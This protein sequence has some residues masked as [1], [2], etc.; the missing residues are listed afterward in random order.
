MHCIIFQ[1]RRVLQCRY[2]HLTAPQHQQF[3]TVPS[4]EVAEFTYWFTPN[5]CTSAVKETADI[6]FCSSAVKET[7]DIIFC[8]SALKETADI[9]FCTS[10][11]KETADIIFRSGYFYHILY[12]PI[13]FGV[14]SYLNLV[15]FNN[16]INNRDYR[17]QCHWR[18][19]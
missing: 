17:R 13:V 5:F 4:Q 16:V 19:N 1:D 7:A 9:I 8:T 6:I 14:L 11:V 10:T 12:T 3:C 15:L 2:E 18:M